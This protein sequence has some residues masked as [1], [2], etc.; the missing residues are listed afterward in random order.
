MT[1][2]LGMA[3]VWAM[4]KNELNNEEIA[5]LAGFASAK[6]LGEPNSKILDRLVEEGRLKPM[7]LGTRKYYPLESA[8]QLL[9]ERRSVP[10]GFVVVSEFSEKHGYSHS[11]GPNACRLGKI[12]SAVQVTVDGKR[13][14]WYAE[15]KDLKA[16]FDRD[17]SNS[18]GAAAVKAKG[19]GKPTIMVGE[20]AKTRPLVAASTT[21]ER[22]EQVAKSLAETA[23]RL[24]A[25]LG[26][27]TPAPTA[28][29]SGVDIVITA[30]D[31]GLIR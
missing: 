13:A 27:T 17:K 19:P 22:L 3:S 31:L 24:E 28:K 23:S 1:P 12:P 21:V 18:H 25:I 11:Y 14:T 6:E 10:R 2:G 30:P 16:Y 5:R 26:T 8:K 7:T 4:S 9:A 20:P 15:P 29:S